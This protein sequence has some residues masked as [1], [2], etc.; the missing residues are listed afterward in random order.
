MGSGGPREPGFHS[1]PWR[2]ECTSEYRFFCT[3]PLCTTPFC[4][5]IWIAAPVPFPHLASHSH[6]PLPYS[7]PHLLIPVTSSKST[8]WF[9]HFRPIL[10]PTHSLSHLGQ[11]VLVSHTP[12]P[13]LTSPNLSHHSPVFLVPFHPQLTMSSSCSLCLKSPTYFNIFKLA[14][15]VSIFLRKKYLKRKL[16]CL[17]L[18]FP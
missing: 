5:D 11:P 13:T 17:I 2:N 10:Y 9:L 4:P 12:A 7:V 14:I 1:K 6:L 8:P 18:I 16:N 15:T 3:P